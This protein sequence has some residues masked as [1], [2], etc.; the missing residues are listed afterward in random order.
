MSY[1]TIFG[2]WPFIR[3]STLLVVLILLFH[4]R[5]RCSHFVVVPGFTLYLPFSSCH[6]VID[7][8]SRFV[9]WKRPSPR[10]RKNPWAVGR[11]TVWREKNSDVAWHPYLIYLL[12]VSDSIPTHATV[13]QLHKS[14]YSYIYIYISTINYRISSR[15]ITMADPTPHT[16]AQNPTNQP[17]EA[18]EN[19]GDRFDGRGRAFD[20][21]AFVVNE[22][23]RIILNRY[24]G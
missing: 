11:N 19:R 17:V 15:A 9:Y 10:Q 18:N 7:G 3:D 22:E 1:W 24:L 21:C 8:G 12:V 23:H 2:N 16:K 14:L 13:G 4:M 20:K 6:K 5:H